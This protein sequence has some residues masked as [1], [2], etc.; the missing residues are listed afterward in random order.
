[1]NVL[2]SLHR[3]HWLAVIILFL[4]GLTAPAA[5][6]FAASVTFEAVTAAINSSAPGDT[7]IM[8]PGT[9]AWSSPLTLSGVSLV[10]SGT[11]QTFI[12]DNLDRNVNTQPPLIFLHSSTNFF[13]IGNFQILPGN[14]TKN[15]HGI[16][17]TDMA[18]PCRI[19]HIF[20]NQVNDKNIMLY[21]ANQTLI[22]HCWFYL[23][24]NEGVLVRDT[25]YGD[26]SWASPMNYG[27]QNV[28]CIEDCIF[29]NVL[30]GVS[31]VSLD[32]EAGARILFR[33]NAVLN[34]L[35][36]N[37]GTESGA[38]LRGCRSFEI[39]SNLFAMDPTWSFPYAMSIRS[40]SGVI[41]GNTITGVKYVTGIVNYRNGERF[42]PWGGADG[43]SPWD[44]VVATNVISGV[45]SGANGANYLEVAGAN[46][47]VNQ[48]VG[49]TV[50]N[51][52]FSGASWNF[53]TIVSNSATQILFNP[54]KD[55]GAM[56]F[57]TGQRFEVN[58]IYPM[59]DQPGIGSGDLIVGDQQ[60][61][62]PNPTVAGLGV[63]KWPHQVSDPIYA[64]SN[65]LNGTPGKIGSDFPNIKE[66]RDFFNDL[67]KPGY[68]PLPYP[69]PLQGSGN[70]GGSGGS[71]GS[72][73]SLQPPA[74]V[75]VQQ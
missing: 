48:W 73:N 7:V 65:S 33:Y 74:R 27:R 75:W 72:T 59:L 42:D 54:A 61:W 5:T 40:G 51:K 6:N 2:F 39:Y 13:E 34:N 63:A 47:T 45:H 8:P 68:E 14:T 37:H 29:T 23:K 52:D 58:Q 53:S 35:W 22:D 16:I 24:G 17:A 60:P 49:Y 56:T 26:A 19:H 46:W 36:A 11:N 66:G 20:F 28:P 62:G 3:A 18:G 1:M 71:G 44:N 32:A 41:F 12:I 10:G 69:H 15:W 9:A 43:Y 55:Y 70:G 31:S 30:V 50:V 21:G 57:S 64:W 67:P 25:G 4:A 38:R